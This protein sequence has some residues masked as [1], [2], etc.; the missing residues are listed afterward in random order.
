MCD[1]CELF[2]QETHHPLGS[3][4]T[5]QPNC[6]SAIWK[7]F[8]S[9]TSFIWLSHDITNSWT[10]MMTRPRCFLIR[11]CKK[12]KP[13]PQNCGIICIK[14]H[15]FILTLIKLSQYQMTIRTPRS[16]IWKLLQQ[17]Q[18]TPTSV[19]CNNWHFSRK[20]VSNSRMRPWAE[21]KYAF[22]T[23]YP[24]PHL[25]DSWILVFKLDLKHSTSDF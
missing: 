21:T 25:T 5:P 17:T 13:Y 6:T 18:V 15:H 9:L 2:S 8:S 11:S 19:C 24:V 10:E 4:P 20:C 3:P 1:F 23:V 14:W 16:P 7:P 12:K 22:I